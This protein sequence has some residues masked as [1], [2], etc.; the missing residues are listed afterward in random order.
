MV[1]G[2]KMVRKHLLCCLIL[3]MVCCSLCTRIRT[4]PDL[5]GS[6][7]GQSPPGTSPELFA[8]GIVSTGLDE[9]N[10]VFSPD[11]REFYFCVRNFAGAVSVFQMKIEGS[12]WSEPRLL[13][14]ASNHG[15]IDITMSPNGDTLLFSS[16]RPLPG[17]DSPKDDYDFW[18]AE[19]TEDSWSEAKY[20]GSQINSLRHDFYPMMTRNGT[21]Y[22]SSQREGPGTN[23]IYRSKRIDG[24][25]GDAEKLS[26]AINTEH[27]EFDPYISPDESTL[28]FTSTREEGFGSGD[29]YIS[30]RNGRGDWTQAKNMGESIN[31]SGAEYCAMVSPDGKYLF[32]T[33]A[34]RETATVPE[35][36]FRYEDFIKA[37]N[38]PKNVYSDIY[39]IDA[40]IIESF[41]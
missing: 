24:E 41:K 13:P 2:V 22:F 30:F 17:N 38:N 4:V 6:F 8:P 39:W 21:I 7:L 5:R 19:R 23:N 15:D 11:G 34:R 26:G 3:G 20:L 9:L 28:I 40:A 27:R 32:F 25:Y 12:F 37:H 33:S 14:F 29:L 1:K 18:M 36:P 10:S 31:T 35:K 16:R